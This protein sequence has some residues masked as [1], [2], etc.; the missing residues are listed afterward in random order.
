MEN[1]IADFAKDLQYSPPV[2][3]IV[4]FEDPLL[5]A[6]LAERAAEIFVLEMKLR[7]VLSFMYLAAYQLRDPFDL[8]GEEQVEIPQRERPTEEQMKESSENQFFHITFSQYVHLNKRKQSD[9]MNMIRDS[10]R[11]DVLRRELMRSPIEDEQDADLLNDLKELMDPIERMRNCVAH[12]RRPSTR[13]RQNYFRTR[14]DLEKRL[15][16]YLADLRWSDSQ[17]RRV[18]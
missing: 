3:H 11:Y 12:N 14:P 13:L 7:R 6:D 8:L 16:G 4:K 18:S 2:F 5:Q 10:E 17:D 15:D 9:L 1:V